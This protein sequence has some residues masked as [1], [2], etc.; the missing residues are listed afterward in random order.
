[1]GNVQV[2]AQVP[3]PLDG[4]IAVEVKILAQIVVVKVHFRPYTDVQLLNQ[5]IFALGVM[6]IVLRKLHSP[7]AVLGHKPKRGFVVGRKLLVV[8][9]GVPIAGISFEGEKQGVSFF[10]FP[11]QGNGFRFNAFVAVDPILV[12]LED[13]AAVEFKIQGI[14][15]GKP[16][17]PI[18]AYDLPISPVFKK[19]VGGQQPHIRPIGKGALIAQNIRKS[20]SALSGVGTVLAGNQV[21][22]GLVIGGQPVQPLLV[23]LMNEFGRGQWIIDGS[24]INGV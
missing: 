10:S 19:A 24:R 5:A 17:Q 11:V 20:F 14:K 12:G 2:G 3:F 6:G 4:D 22:R 1:M 18:D 21:G 13:I 7:N 16:Q 15:V 8:Q 23:A 9:F